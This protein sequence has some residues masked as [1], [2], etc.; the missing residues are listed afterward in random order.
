VLPLG[1]LCGD[2]PEALEVLPQARLEAAHPDAVAIGVMQ[3]A[4]FGDELGQ[5]AQLVNLE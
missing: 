5:F 1:G 2:D 3:G 4:S